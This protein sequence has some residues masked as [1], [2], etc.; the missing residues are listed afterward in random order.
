MPE[1]QSQVTCDECGS[2]VPIVTKHAASTEDGY[3]LNNVEK[4]TPEKIVLM[5]QCDCHNIFTPVFEY[6]G[7]E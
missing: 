2:V 6:T 1:V 4:A 7:N 5:V 3:M